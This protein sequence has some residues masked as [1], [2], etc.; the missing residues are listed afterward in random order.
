MTDWNRLAQ[1]VKFSGHFAG[2]TVA[3]EDAYFSAFVGAS[4]PDTGNWRA[5]LFEVVLTAAKAV[6][7]KSRLATTFR[8]DWASMR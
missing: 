5:A 3:D 6:Q 4:A 7:G 1:N 2:R 8:N